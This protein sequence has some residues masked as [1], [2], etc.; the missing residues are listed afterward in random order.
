MCSNTPSQIDPDP[1]RLDSTRV[2]LSEFTDSSWQ[3][4]GPLKQ[5]KPSR[6]SMQFPSWP[7]TDLILPESTLLNPSEPDQGVQKVVGRPIGSVQE[8]R[9]RLSLSL[10]FG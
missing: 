2:D 4:T 5:L 8:Y 3:P 10:S 7:T 9:Y 6:L 1:T